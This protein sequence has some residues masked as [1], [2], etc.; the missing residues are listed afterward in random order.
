M[1]YIELWIW[2]MDMYEWIPLE[3]NSTI[4]SRES[5]DE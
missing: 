3:E 2:D 5:L 4:P 1:N